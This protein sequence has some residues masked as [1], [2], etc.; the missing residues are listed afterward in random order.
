MSVTHVCTVPC[1][2]RRGRWISWDWSY[3]Q[4]EAT[5]WVLGTQ[6][7][8]L[9]EQPGLLTADLPL[10]PQQGRYILITENF[11]EK[12]VNGPHL[13]AAIIVIG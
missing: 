4:L 12:Q 1:E 9:H 5:L 7:S 10:Q 13:P 11:S 8:P 6:Q 2:V 3:K